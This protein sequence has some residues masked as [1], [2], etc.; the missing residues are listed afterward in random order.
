MSDSQNKQRFVNLLDEYIQRHGCVVHHSRG[1][2][3]LL[4]VTTALQRAKLT[5][6]ALVGDATDLTVLLCFYVDMEAHDLF[7]YSQS[8]SRSHISRV[9]NIKSVRE[10]LGCNVCEAIL[11]IRAVG[12]CDTTSR[13][14]GI[15]KG[16]PLK[17]YASS[18][19]FQDS[20]KQG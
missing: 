4:I 8:K 3:D 10:K 14:Y 16:T 19:V 1:D 2:A 9:W 12:G 13:L 18:K 15:G 20:S 17:K 11:C 6:T 5:T 7:M